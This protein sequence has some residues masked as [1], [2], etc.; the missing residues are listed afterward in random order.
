MFPFDPNTPITIPLVE[1]YH[2]GTKVYFIHTEVSDKDM[3][4]IMTTMINFPILYVPS[5]A[6]IP[7]TNLSKVYVFTNGIPGSGPYGRGP[8]MFQIHVFDSI[9]GMK[10]YSNFKTPYFVTW[11]EN[12]TARVLTS[13]DEIMKLKKMVK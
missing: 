4:D 1:G 12:A 11:N 7:E 5:L 3:A 13:I 6:N 10:G 8:F 9:P 2:N